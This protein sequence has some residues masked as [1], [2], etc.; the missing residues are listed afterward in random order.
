MLVLRKLGVPS[1][2]TLDATLPCGGERVNA[3][4]SIASGSMVADMARSAFTFSFFFFV[5]G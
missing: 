3:E 4:A 5:N 1:M 2:Y